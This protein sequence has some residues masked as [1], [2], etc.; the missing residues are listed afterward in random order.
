MNFFVFTEGKLL[1]K[2]PMMNRKIESSEWRQES[3]SVYGTRD[4]TWHWWNTF[5]TYT[6]YHSN[7]SLALELTSN[8]PNFVDL[9]RWMGEPIDLLIISTSL[10]SKSGAIPMLSVEHQDVVL[11]FLAKT[12]CQLALKPEHGSYQDCTGYMEYMKYLNESG[13]NENILWNS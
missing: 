12:N 11:K 5:R 3:D 8:L 2:I 4:D 10:F 6:D 13:E 7:I 1:I 9:L